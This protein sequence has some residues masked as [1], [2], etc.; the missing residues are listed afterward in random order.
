M[1]AL[2][3]LAVAAG[4]SNL[5]LLSARFAP[6]LLASPTLA[7]IFYL[8]PARLL[9]AQKWFDRYGA[10]ALI[11]GRHVPGLRIPLTVVA[12]TLHLPYRIFLPSV[13][14]SAT[15]WA[16]LWLTLGALYAPSVESFLTNHS[17]LY[18]LAVLA[19]LVFLA[20]S[21]LRVLRAR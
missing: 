2:T 5:Y 16:I 6:R 20:I 14:V 12:G 1:V 21:T 3:V 8:P 7:A 11:F 15:F 17:W 13:I 19:T 9:R 18:F 4:S 10:L